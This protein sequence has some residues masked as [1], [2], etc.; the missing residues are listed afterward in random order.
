MPVPTSSEITDKGAAVESFTRRQP[1]PL[2]K[3]RRQIEGRHRSLVAADSSHPG[4]RY[5]QGNP[6]RGLQRGQFLPLIVVPEH[7]AVVTGEDNDR[8]LQIPPLANL[9][10]QASEALIEMFDRGGP[11]AAHLLMCLRGDIPGVE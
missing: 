4:A 10:Y 9:L 1:R 11:V 8:V 7:L 2:K 3:A 6:D 5:C